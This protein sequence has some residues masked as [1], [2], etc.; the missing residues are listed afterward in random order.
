[1]ATLYLLLMGCLGYLAF[2]DFKERQVFGFLLLL[3]ALLLG[4]LHRVQVLDWRVFGYHCSFNGLLVTG[5]IAVLFLYTRWIAQK[6]FLGHSIGLG[7][8]L[9][10]YALA[11]GFPPLAFVVIFTGSLLFSLLMYMA[12]KHRLREKTVPLA[13]LM[14]LFV[15]LV[16]SYQALTKSINVYGY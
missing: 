15:I 13:G 1:M 11:V 14:G 2:Q 8:L 10:F 6:P 3:I 4:A 12:I 16:L 7:D 5:V 9:F